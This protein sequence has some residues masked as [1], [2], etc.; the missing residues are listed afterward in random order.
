MRCKSYTVVLCC[1]VQLATT[2]SRLK[3]SDNLPWSWMDLL[4]LTPGESLVKPFSILGEQMAATSICGEPFPIGFAGNDPVGTPL[5]TL[6]TAL[7]H[8][9]DSRTDEHWGVT[10]MILDNLSLT[11]YSGYVLIALACLY[12]VIVD[13]SLWHGL[14]LQWQQMAAVA[15]DAVAVVAVTGLTH[16][17]VLYSSWLDLPFC[18]NRR[19]NTQ[20]R[21]W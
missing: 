15:T 5:G 4:H 21:I 8:R 17:Q 13:H 6:A 20:T 1:I 2:K 16:P 7:A 3:F 19:S 18:R 10:S 14:I 12:L 11:L 9:N